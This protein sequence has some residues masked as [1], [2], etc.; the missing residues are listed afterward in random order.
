[1]RP[2]NKFT[3]T[4]CR[5]ILAGHC[6]EHGTC[7]LGVVQATM[8]TEDLCPP[9]RQLARAKPS[10]NTRQITSACLWPCSGWLICSSLS[11]SL[12]ICGDLLRTGHKPEQLFLALVTFVLKM[13]ALWPIYPCTAGP[14]RIPARRALHQTGFPNAMY[15]NRGLCKV[16]DFSRELHHQWRVLKPPKKQESPHKRPQSRGKTIVHPT[17]EQRCILNRQNRRT[18]L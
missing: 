17:K 14:W 11:S 16:K 4:I 13:K 3:Y 7:Q 5:D 2:Q 8:P 6:R 1:M 12:Q 15:P 9:N 18:G 10:V